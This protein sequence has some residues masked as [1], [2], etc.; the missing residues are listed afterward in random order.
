MEEGRRMFQIF[1]ARMFE[2]RVLT[3][4]REKVAKERQQKLIE[5]L[6]EE[7]RQDSQR[8]AKKAKEAQKRK[9]KAAQK[10]AAAAE[11]KA[12]KEAEKAAEIEARLQQEAA[13]A[14]E[15]KLKAEEKRK[16]KEAQKKAEEEERLRKEAERQRRIH[17]QKERQA[18][19][20]RKAREAKERE[21][22]AKDDAKLKEKEARERKDREV[23]D[24]KDKPDLDKRDKDVKAKYEKDIRDKQKQE[25]KVAQKVAAL[26]TSVPITLPKRPSQH[27]SNPIPALPQQP[28]VAFQSPQIAVATPALPK[29]PT[30]I[31]PRQASQ[32]DVSATSSHPGSQAGSGTSQNA[33]P[34]ANTP[35]HRS[36]AG[37]SS[38]SGPQPTQP[39]QAMSPLQSVAKLP[40]TSQP[41]PFNMPPM[42]MAFPPGLPQQM[43]PGF[44]NRMHHDPMFP[45]IGA[46]F[47]PGPNMMPMPPGLNGPMNGRGFPIPHPPPGFPQPTPD[48]LSTPFPGSLPKE[49]VLP[50]HS[51]QPSGGF[52]SGSIPSTQPISR[53]APIGR[54][55]SVVHG[56]RPTSDSP[57]SAAQRDYDEMQSHH[58][59]SSALLDDSDEPFLPSL[60]DFGQNA[61]RGT[62]A[63]GPAGR[64]GFPPAPFGGIDPASLFH[65]SSV[66]GH[67]SQPPPG[68]NPF[69]AAP[70]PPP[71]F[72]PA[73]WA[74]PTP[75]FSGPVGMGRSS[76]PRSVIIRQMLCRVCRELSEKSKPSSS[77]TSTPDSSKKSEPVN[78]FISLDAIKAQ[79]DI[80]NPSNE[81]PVSEDD[82]LAL[83]ET[84]GNM[85]NGGGSFD[86]REDG[87][88]RYIRWVPS[89]NNGIGP[90]GLPHLQRAVGAPGEIGS[91]II[92]SGWGR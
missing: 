30:P 68:I 72:G 14:E 86:V 20:E 42:G 88:R 33:S 51:R 1:A 46:G 21:K 69:G 60:P 75:A 39:S 63:P 40:S 70:P 5:E 17:E 85:Q 13:R 79:V 80:L 10:K 48:Q 52:D 12:R 54:P 83:C 34:S 36:P 31:R 84:E 50:T 4:Y 66:W 44:G 78:E 28:P 49:S 62:A 91:P 71:G 22:K 89:M 15:A 41:G 57:G 23:R 38:R 6:D 81:R 74:S 8:K 29:A 32:Q 16:K 19:L 18:E 3:A 7:T 27:Q 24:R 53:P 26:S 90:D 61:R 47:R 64:P 56:Q 37:V 43:P 92:G 59:G 2:Q 9:E 77:V 65:T 35:V 76:Q 58:L 45:P 82:L 25:E 87:P 67:P 73:A 55:G 11:E